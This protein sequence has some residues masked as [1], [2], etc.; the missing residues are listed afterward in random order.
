MPS[1]HNALLGALSRHAHFSEFSEHLNVNGNILTPAQRRALALYNLTDN[2]A[3]QTPS[4]VLVPGTGISA[5]VGTVF[6]SSQIREG[7]Y[8]RTRNYID[9]T[10]LASSTTDL[11]IIGVGAGAAYLG[12]VTAAGHGAP[13]H[14]TGRMVCI[15][16]PATGVTDIDLYSATENTGVFDGGIAA[17]VETAILTAGGAWTAGLSR[18]FTAVTAANQYLYLT[19]GAAGVPG[20]YTAGRFLIEFEGT[21]FVGT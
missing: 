12:Q 2:F 8:V 5:G 3:V 6:S 14:I 7:N 9:L 17:L 1:T 21:I 4:G 13:T 18:P 16:A 20:T 19:C 10:G 15:E 11:D